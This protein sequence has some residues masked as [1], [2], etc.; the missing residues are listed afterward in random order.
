MIS[1]ATPVRGEVLNKVITEYQS[2]Y[3]KI[4][5]NLKKRT[6]ILSILVFG[7]IITGDLWEKSDIDLI[8]IVE[9]KLDCDIMNIYTEENKIPIHIRFIQKEIFI[10]LCKGNNKG[11]HLHRIFCSSKL[12]FSRDKE[13]DSLYNEERYYNEIYIKKWNLYYFSKVIK[14][15]AECKKYL[16]LGST[17]NSYTIASNVLRSFA[18]LI[19]NFRGYMINRDVVSMAINFDNEFQLVVDDF[20]NSKNTLDTKIS[21]LV[22]Y[23]ENNIEKNL[24]RYTSVV[25]EYMSNIDVQVSSSELL[26]T[27]IF[28]DYNIDM[29]EVLEQLYLN[30]IIKKE[31]RSCMKSCG[32]SLINENVYYI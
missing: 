23:I 27:D 13:I 2:G 26:N 5:E 18:K 24:T 17:Y 11:G 8:V 9:E 14:G 31:K 20:L 6:G 12:V 19:V 32:T 16:Y 1:T 28:K 10:T 25:I 21:N 15:I 22:N 30:N 4:V 29:E 3:S 7:S